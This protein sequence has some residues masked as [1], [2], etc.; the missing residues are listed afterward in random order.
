M[1]IR[2]HDA[3]FCLLSFE[4]P[5]RYSQA[6]G[7]GVRISHLAEKFAR[8]KFDT[9]LLFVGDPVAPGESYAPAAG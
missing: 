4:G 8:L 6:G 5:D 2:P 7:L 1:M 3:V 9:H